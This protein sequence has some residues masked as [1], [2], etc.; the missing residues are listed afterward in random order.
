METL[1]KLQIIQGIGYA[2]QDLRDQLINNSNIK[3]TDLVLSC[4]YTDYGGTF[5]DKVTIAYFKKYYKDNIISEI[6]SYNG[7]N[8]FIFGEI[9]NKF[10]EENESYPLG[11]ENI[12]EFFYNMEYEIEERDFKSF[13]NDLRKYSNYKIKRGAMNFLRENRSGYYPVLTT[14][15]DFNSTELEEYLVENKQIIKNK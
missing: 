6:T 13:L 15:V 7:E 5:F 12:E 14:G 8:A 9:V 10:I 11:F 2:S 1:T 4:A 3:D